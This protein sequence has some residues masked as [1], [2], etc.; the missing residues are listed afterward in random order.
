M[1]LLTGF[2]VVQL[3][4]GLAAA[5]CGRL[6]ADLGANVVCTDP[7]TATP[8]AAYLNHGKTVVADGAAH[9]ALSHA[10]L[11]VCEGGPAALRDRRHGP[12]DI[13]PINATAALVLISPFGQTGP[14]ADQPATDLTLFYASGIAHLL[15]GQVD[16]LAEPPIRPVGQQ[17]AF[18]GGIAA[19]CAGMH[20][21]LAAAPGALI[22]VSIQEALATLAMT[23]L[24]RAGRGG[25]SRA[26]KRL[27][28]GNGATVCIL[29]ARDGYAAISPREDRQWAA[30]RAAMGAPAWGN[31]PRFATKADRVA[32]WDALH[33]L[34][35]A[36]S[37]QHDKQTI[38]DIAQQAHVPS[39]PL[40]EP[41]EQLASAQLAHR[42][43]YRPLT[44]GDRTVRAPGPPFGLRIAPA[45]AGAADKRCAPGPMPLSGVRVLDFSWVIAGPTTT[46][47]L[48]AMGAEVI[49]VEAPGTGDPG[50]AS[51]LHSVLG[52]AKRGI[53][54]DLKRPE[55][56]EV[57]RALAARCDVLVE[58]F[59]TG[60]MDRLGLGAAALRAVNPDLI[61]VSASGLGRTGPESHAVAYG[62]LLQ[63]YAG[64]AGLNRHS[65]LPPRIGLAWLDPMCGLMLAF[66]VAAS[67]WQRRRSGRTAR[68]DFSMLEAMLWTMAKPLLAAQ[69]GAPPQPRGNRSDHCVPHGAY[70]CIGDDD[71]ISIAVRDDDDWRRLCAI[72]VPLS[73]MAGLGLA[74]RHARREAID[75]TLSAWARPHQ[76][77][78]AADELMRAG[79]PAAALATSRDLVESPHLRARGFWDTDGT[80]VLPGLPWRASFGGITSPAPGLGADTETVL[81]DTLGLSSAEIAALRASGALA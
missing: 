16:D 68:V 37:R 42:G 14:R 33:A 57:A 11:I 55:A 45:R 70:R 28:D 9:D 62:T 27:T 20:A 26:R 59:A 41:A 15:T 32:N 78:A 43:F 2:R 66:I 50:R 17:S 71:W 5:V 3:G 12:D 46:R 23:E 22:D 65:D 48:A 81:V 4:Q 30:W 60:V 34:M 13:R 69:L 63:C 73:A 75:D 49:K 44:L 24:A 29:P 31:D 74:E 58:N 1:S 21:A 18:I 54:L 52:Q 36:W 80:G 47:Y 72:V 7:D 51:E 19:A 39:F 76:A 79:I 77:R 64:F 35:S 6:L 10:E 56:V 38:A 8:L 40:R 53:V 67:I 61:Y 25:N